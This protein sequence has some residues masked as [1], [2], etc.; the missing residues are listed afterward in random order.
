MDFIGTCWEDRAWIP[1]AG[2]LLQPENSQAWE[3]LCGPVPR[4]MA[5]GRKV[6]LHGEIHGGSRT[7]ELKCGMLCQV[8]LAWTCWRGDS[9]GE[10]H[11]FRSRESSVLLM[12]WLGLAWRGPGENSQGWSCSRKLLVL[13]SPTLPKGEAFQGRF[14][15]SWS[16][17]L[18]PALIQS[19]WT[20]SFGAGG[21]GQS[22][23]QA[24][25]AAP[26]KRDREGGTTTPRALLLPVLPQGLPGSPPGHPRKVWPCRSSTGRVWA[27]PISAPPRASCSSQEEPTP[28]F[29]V[30]AAAPAPV[31]SESMCPLLPVPGA[32]RAPAVGLWTGRFVQPR[33]LC[34]CWRHSRMCPGSAGDCACAVPFCL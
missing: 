16:P 9:A 17:G 33:Q 5:V 24:R 29:L 7:E 13:D 18:L 32:S 34:C 8:K 30:P 28:L 14:H 26:G 6:V 4:Q 19:R 12:E 15:Q 25:S 3:Q 10:I 2:R 23:A 20:L 1:W 11:P 27:R 31:G 22:R 21:G